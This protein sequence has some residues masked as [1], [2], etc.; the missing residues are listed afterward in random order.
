MTFHI[1]SINIWIFS[2]EFSMKKNWEISS[3]PLT[4]SI[5]E[6]LAATTNQL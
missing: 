5:I 2:S 1:F 6:G 4:N 3:S